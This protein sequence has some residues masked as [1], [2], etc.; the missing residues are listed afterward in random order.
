MAAVTPAEVEDAF[1]YG[2]LVVDEGMGL[3]YNVVGL[4]T[5]DLDGRTLILGWASPNKDIYF[6][7]T[8]AQIRD[9]GWIVTRNGHRCLLR[10]LTK[11]DGEQT[12]ASLY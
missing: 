8:D 5:K 2:A 6:D 10:P 11:A 1:P 9:D 3:N 4:E 7:A 12:E